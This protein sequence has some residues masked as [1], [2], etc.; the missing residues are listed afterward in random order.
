MLDSV[1]F[2]QRRTNLDK[3]LGLQ[4]IK[5]TVEAAPWP[6]QIML[7]EPMCRRD[8]GIVWIHR[9]GYRIQRMLAM[10]GNRIL[11]LFVQQIGNRRF[12]WFVMR[13]QWPIDCSSRSIKPA[14]AFGFHDERAIARERVHAGGILFWLVIGRL[15]RIEIRIVKSGPFLLLSVPPDIFLSLGP[16]LTLRIGGRAVVH[17]APIMWPGKSPIGTRV[18]VWITP[19]RARTVA[20]FR[21]KKSALD[22]TTAR[23]DAVD[24]QV[25]EVANLPAIFYGVAVDFFQNFLD[26]RFLVI[27]LRSP[28]RRTSRCASFVSHRQIHEPLIALS[29]RIGV[30][31]F[32]FRAE[33]IDEP[34][35]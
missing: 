33:V 31:F 14:L 19:A 32:T 2:R 1:F 15:F 3:H 7:S 4:F 10:R 9:R 24:F 20:T 17:H 12:D 35:I 23:G 34:G 27:F 29:F 5:P 26:V 22:P 18:V 11:S 28:F 25:Y 13:R 6:A 8:D 16:G 21:R 30:P